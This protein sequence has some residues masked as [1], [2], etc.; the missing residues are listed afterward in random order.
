LKVKSNWKEG[1]ER[2]QELLL[3]EQRQETGPWSTVTISVASFIVGFL[4]GA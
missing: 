2:I 1:G 4:C 3:L